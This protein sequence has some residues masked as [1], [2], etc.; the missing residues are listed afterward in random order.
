MQGR[1]VVQRRSVVR[2]RSRLLSHNCA[3]ALGLRVQTVA[4]HVRRIENLTDGDS[5]VPRRPFRHV[6]RLLGG[7]PV[8]YEADSPLR[9]F[10]LG[11]PPVDAGATAPQAVAA[12]EAELRAAHGR[13]RIRCPREFW[14][15]HSRCDAVQSRTA[16][17]DPSLHRSSL[18][19]TL[20][21]TRVFILEKQIFYVQ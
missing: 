6:G 9:R 5:E 14:V 2:R 8:F 3:S 1:S 10:L 4:I 19:A 13:E 11:Q 17:M 16:D 18:L 15:D 20:R 21:G 12:G 7:L